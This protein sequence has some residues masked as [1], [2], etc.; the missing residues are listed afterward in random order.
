MDKT[1]LHTDTISPFCTGPIGIV[2]TIKSGDA[3]K[4]EKLINELKIKCE[5]LGMLSVIFHSEGGDV[6]E[7]IKLGKLIRANELITAVDRQYKCFSACI[8]AFVGG[9][10][11]LPDGKMGIHRPY[12]ASLSTKLTVKEI[13]DQRD[14]L[15]KQ[16]KDYFAE[17][18]I[19]IALVET[20]MA[21][22]PEDM[23][24]LSPIELTHYRLDGI[25]ASYDEKTI[26]QFA[27][28]YG[29]TSAIMRQRKSSSYK[30]DIDNYDCRAAALWG[31]PLEIYK[32]RRNQYY[33][34]C[35]VTTS[36]ELKL[37]EIKVMTGRVK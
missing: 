7:A 29:T 5:S 36:Q 31:L 2:G 17:M 11:R 13:K 16:I 34:S 14:E 37:C 25:D 1:K 30:C 15:N 28:W 27:E 6:F 4:L 23:K 10:H 33:N 24:L 35:K 19:N 22:P 9:V 12:F 18:D 3:T 32:V 20:M 26:A 8:I 21:I